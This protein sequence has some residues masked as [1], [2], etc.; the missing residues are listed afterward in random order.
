MADLHAR[1]LQKWLRA[2]GR[3]SSSCCLALL[4]AACS[5]SEPERSPVASSQEDLVYGHDDRV[6][7]QDSPWKG[8]ASASTVA[9]ISPESLH[10]GSASLVR[11]SGVS[12][13][14]AFSLCAE[15]RFRDELS[16]AKCS[17]VLIG[18]DLV[19]TAGHCFENDD[20]C[21][22]FAYVFDYQGFEAVE[23]VRLPADAVYGCRGIVARAV[24]SGAKTWNDFAIVQ[25]DRAAH[26]RV[27][28]RLANH[29]WVLGAPAVVIGYPLGLPAKVDP[30]ARTRFID[31]GE[32]YALISSDTYVGSSG[33]PAFDDAGAL[34]GLLVAGRNDFAPD[35]SECRSTL[36]VADAGESGE[37]IAAPHAAV[38]VMCSRAFPEPELCTTEPRCGD[39]WCS[40]GEL[41]SCLTD[42][43]APA[44]HGLDCPG[45]SRKRSPADGGFAASPGAA[46]NCGVARR[47]DT[48]NVLVLLAGVA[49]A[50]CARRLTRGMA[51]K[52]P[53]MRRTPHETVG[54]PHVL[55][56]SWPNRIARRASLRLQA[57]LDR[58]RS[59]WGG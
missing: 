40:A 26:D 21:G 37:M 41:E 36:R 43:R 28:V 18:Q 42:C 8:V 2:P 12:A 49:G 34:W 7:A 53:N 39:D 24:P 16:A 15:E 33:S 56:R 35:A 44:C 22:R 45:A 10:S 29:P 46:G 9:L 59:R 3:C 58:S 4:L 25:L 30:G 47:A 17:G 14:R 1:R 55:S 13:G 11:V 38:S 20:D 57:S 6:E 48:V 5:S 50:A 54:S 27:P 52:R 19:L 32:N 51:G 23:D 31:E